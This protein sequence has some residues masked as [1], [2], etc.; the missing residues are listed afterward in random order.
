MTTEYAN[1]NSTKAMKA[2]NKQQGYHFF[3]KG[4]MSSFNSVVVPVHP[5]TEKNKPMAGCVFI[6]Q[7]RMD[8]SHPKA[9]TVRAMRGNGSIESVSDFQEY[10]SLEEACERAQEKAKEIENSRIFKRFSSCFE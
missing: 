10:E 8:Y 3:D 5:P 7:E 6:T 2:Y 9:Y 4:V 1:F